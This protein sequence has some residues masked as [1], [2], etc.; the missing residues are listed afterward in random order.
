VSYGAL[1]RACWCVIPPD[2][3][4]IGAPIGEAC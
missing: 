3:P 4:S 1:P 2:K